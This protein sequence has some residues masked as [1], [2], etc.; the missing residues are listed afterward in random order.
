MGLKITFVLPH[1]TLSGGNKVSLM[2]ADRLAARGHEV[3]VLHGWMPRLKDRVR[4]RLRGGRPD[5]GV[6][7]RVRVINANT[8]VDRLAEF[9]P[10]ADVLVATW[11]HTVEAVSGAPP[12]KGRK[13]HLVQG[14]EIFPYLPARS[15]SVYR[16]P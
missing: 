16:L 9:L 13:F 14:H 10:D 2:Y 6:S 7:E 3:T 4:Q 12:S 8:V 11:W 5:I 1:L 15:A